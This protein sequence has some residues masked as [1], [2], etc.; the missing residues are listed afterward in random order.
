MEIRLPNLHGWREKHAKRE[1]MKVGKDNV[2]ANAGTVIVQVVPKKL[3]C[4]P[5]ERR[6]RRLRADR[7]GQSS[8]S[9]TAYVGGTLHFRYERVRD[10]LFL[11]MSL[12]LCVLPERSYCKRQRRKGNFH[13]PACRDIFRA[14]GAAGG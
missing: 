10:G 3:R 12:A 7:A 11:R 6:M 4:G 14:A 1:S 8:E 13:R 9:R 5:L 2:K